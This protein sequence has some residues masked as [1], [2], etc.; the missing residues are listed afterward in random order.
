M[1]WD[2]SKLYYAAKH[3][4]AKHEYSYA[5]NWSFTSIYRKDEHYKTLKTKQKYGLFFSRDVVPPLQNQ[6]HYSFVSI[7]GRYKENKKKLSE[8]TV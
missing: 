5:I 2:F 3:T 1:S 4:L 7:T 8:V 6:T